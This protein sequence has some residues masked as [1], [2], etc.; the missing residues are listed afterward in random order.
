MNKE[1]FDKIYTIPDKEAF[2]QVKELA[3]MRACLLLIHLAVP[4]L[5]H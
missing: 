2:S 5:Q 1:H 4:L 3:E